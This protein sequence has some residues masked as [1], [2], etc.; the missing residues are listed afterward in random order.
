MMH[1]LSL[2]NPMDGM[3]Y[4]TLFLATARYEMTRVELGR[5]RLPRRLEMQS[6][7]STGAGPGLLHILAPTNNK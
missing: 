1:Y 3:G 6:P 2:F 4:R 7:G 5:D